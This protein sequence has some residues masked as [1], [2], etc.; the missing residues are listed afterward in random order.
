[1]RQSGQNTE[2]TQQ[3]ISNQK[4]L[5]KFVISTLFRSIYDALYLAN[6]KLALLDLAR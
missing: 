3:K 1:M 6:G 5:L 2:Q 4:P